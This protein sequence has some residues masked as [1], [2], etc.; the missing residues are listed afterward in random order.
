MEA[1][2]INILVEVTKTVSLNWVADWVRVI[3][4]RSFVVTSQYILY[5]FVVNNLNITTVVNS[6]L[7]FE[8]VYAL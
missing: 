4:Y 1:W 6:H 2:L 7:Q 5:C 8:K 3:L